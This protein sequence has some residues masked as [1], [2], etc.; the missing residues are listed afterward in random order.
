MIT[1]RKIANEVL[2]LESG[3][4]PSDDSELSEAY[5]ILMCRQ[6]AN[7]LLAPMIFDNLNSDDRGSLSMLIAGYEVTVEGKNPNKFIT[8]PEFYQR[9]PFNKGLKA[10]APVSDPTNEYIARQNPGVS[11]GLPCAALEKGQNSYYTEGL[12]SYFDETF[13]LKK[14][15][16]KYVV[17]APD[18][19]G[20]DDPLPL[21]AEMQYD[22]I[23]MVRQLLSQQ[24]IQ[25]KKLDGNKDIG[26]R[27]P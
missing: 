13:D 12:K 25:D 19:I 24:P 4:S 1:L 20:V 26:V 22:L 5:V 2:R 18:N 15:L 14:V 10:I 17:A 27:I 6:A 8:H 21:Y 23:L 7:K 16:A 3:G 11:R 9:L